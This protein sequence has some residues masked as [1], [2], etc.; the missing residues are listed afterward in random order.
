MTKICRRCGRQCPDYSAVCPVCGQNLGMKVERQN[1]QTADVCPVLKHNFN[2]SK[3]QMIIWILF[4]VLQI[5][6]IFAVCKGLFFH[7]K[8][9]GLIGEWVSVSIDGQYLEM[10]DNWVGSNGRFEIDKLIFFEDGTFEY[11]SYD[12]TRSGQYEFV[13]DDKDI[14]M[15]FS[16]GSEL[17][18]EGDFSYSLNKDYLMLSY[19]YFQDNYM[20]EFKRK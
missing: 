12:V 20:L 7:N 13:H 14:H 9:S 5:I 17:Y 19:Q 10:K 16:D 3:K 18:Y 15:I 6:I 11:S 8:T 2:G 4:A 1:S